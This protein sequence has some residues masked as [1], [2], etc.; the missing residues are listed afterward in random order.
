MQGRSLPGDFFKISTMDSLSPVTKAVESRGVF[1]HQKIESERA[2]VVTPP[3]WISKSSS[4]TV[5]NYASLVD[6]TLQTTFP[7]QYAE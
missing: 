4:T 3:F 1:I 2:G 6:M 7:E 5:I